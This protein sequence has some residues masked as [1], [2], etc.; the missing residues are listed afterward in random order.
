[1]NL[2]LSP[3]HDDETLFAAYLCL[4]YRPHVI[5]CYPG[6]PRHGSPGIRQRET[7]AAMG[8]LGCEATTVY[9]DGVDLEE[10]IA[11]AAGVHGV[12]LAPLPEERGHSDHN[13][14]GE[15]AARL[16]PGRVV[17]YTTYTDEG[18]STC[19]E[20]V[21][22]QPGWETLKRLALACYP[23]QLKRRGTRVHFQRPLDEYAVTL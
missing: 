11:A 23:S 10:A 14:V 6:A 18:R 16:F 12:V 7:E 20:P 22:V 17:F 8:V 21:D 5:V 15:L 9:E 4:R 19:G 13:R 3:H 1:M 2:L